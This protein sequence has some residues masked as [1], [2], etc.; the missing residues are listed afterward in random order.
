MLIAF[1]VLGVA[2]LL[3]WF[4][5]RPA[6]TPPAPQ[7]DTT[8]SAR[9]LSRLS[10][11]AGALGC[12][13]FVAVGALGLAGD[14]QTVSIADL[15][16]PIGL[17][18]DPISGLFLVIAFGVAAPVA[19]AALAG[20]ADRRPRLPSAV[21]FV[22]IATALVLCARDLFVLLIGWESLGFAFYLSVGFDRSR[23]GRPR[24]SVLAMGFSKVSG[25]ALLLGGLLL[26]TQSHTLTLVDLGHGAGGPLASLAYAILVFAFATKVGLVPMHVWL[27]PSYASAPGPAR[28]VLAGVAVNVG[29]YGLWRT[30]DA[31]GAPPAWLAG[32]V[33]VIAGISAILG[34]THAAV[35]A[36][37]ASL[38]AWSSVENAGVIVAGFGV[39]LVG[40][41]SHSTPMTAAGLIAGTAQVCAHALGKSLLFVSAADIEAAVGTDDLDRLRGVVRIRR[42][43]GIG[44]M[45]GSLTLAGLPLTAGF[46]SEWLTLEALMQQFRTDD[47]A[48]QL[49][50]AVSAVLVALTVGVAGIAFVR[51][52]GLTVFGR[53][54]AKVRDSASHHRSPWSQTAGV[55]LLASGCLAAAAFAPGLIRLI[56][57]GITPIVGKTGFGALAGSWVLQPV[58]PGFSALS[59]S[60][61]WIV[62]PSYVLVIALM[63]LA[64]SGRRMFAVRRVPAWTSG[65]RGIAGGKGY[66]SFGYANPIRKVLAALLLTRHELREEEERTGGQVGDGRGVR[67]ARL[68]Y[69][70]DVVDVVERYLYRPMVPV[71][72]ALV[73][74][75][76]RLQSGRL[77]AYMAYMLIALL[78]IVAVVTSLASH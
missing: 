16:G 17:R 31:L 70:V 22:L 67:A 57:Q 3:G 2:V 45:I 40:A 39:A 20:D 1:V 43:S 15:L 12:V 61:L 32:T 78:A 23:P 19:I 10:W 48:L 68:G 21:A 50:T 75:A 30:L 59:P 47:L 76:K 64:F 63:T 60:W 66:T 27:P 69:T 73:H 24:A 65:S 7:R 55:V 33:L 4:A 9:A 49:C 25:A 14:A 37:L 44:L 29:F 53:P 56:A 58:Y 8:M 11:A 41:V 6:A 77:D 74:A 13:L 52:I 54:H 71:F 36:N 72:W 5:G 42:V 34:I 18:V 46:A 35:H 28:A 38:I 26:A 51:V 62:I